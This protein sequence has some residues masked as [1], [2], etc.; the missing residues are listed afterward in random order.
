MVIEDAITSFRLSRPLLA[1]LRAYA[2]AEDATQGQVIRRALR[3]ELDEAHS[4]EETAAQAVSS[5]I[6]TLPERSPRDDNGHPNS[7][8]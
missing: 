1:E 3:R 6:Q 7:D 2:A 5:Q 4:D 8:A